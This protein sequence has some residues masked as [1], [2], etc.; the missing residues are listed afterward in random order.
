MPGTLLRAR[1]TVVS[2]KIPHGVPKNRSITNGSWAVCSPG[3]WDTAGR[4]RETGLRGDNTCTEDSKR[5][6]SAATSF[7]ALP[8]V[9]ERPPGSRDELSP[10]KGLDHL[11]VV[12]LAK[13]QGEGQRG[14]LWSIP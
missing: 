2:Q 4:L 7:L 8:G 14:M 3:C 6:L 12:Q 1:L 13:T 10:G 5:G 9:A 11:E